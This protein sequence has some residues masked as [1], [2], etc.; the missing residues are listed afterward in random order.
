[1]SVTINVTYCLLPQ[2]QVTELSRL[3]TEHS[4][5][6]SEASRLERQIAD[7]TQLFERLKLD[8]T[9]LSTEVQQVTTFD[10]LFSY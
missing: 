5:L 8:K 2:D 7:N 9:S 3:K 1:M 10:S 6:Q 4:E